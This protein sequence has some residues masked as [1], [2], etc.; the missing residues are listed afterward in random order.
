M[1]TEKRVLILPLIDLLILMGS[2]SLVI[3]F[4]L[5]SISITTHYEPL[6]IG[7]SSIDFVVMAAVCLGF[8]LTLAAR[9]WVKLNEPRLLGESRSGAL[10]SRKG[11]QIE[12]V[13]AEEEFEV[14]LADAAAG[15][16][17]R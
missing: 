14:P 7:F 11:R 5:K 16:R 13:G 4:V 8:A 10:V 15:A 6:I 12:T 1:G 9:T 17:R 3:G 2:A